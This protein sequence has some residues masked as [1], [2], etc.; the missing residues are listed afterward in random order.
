MPNCPECGK[1][2][3]TGYKICPSCGVGSTVLKVEIAAHIN[4]LR[5]KIQ[6]DP[7][8]ARLCVELG[9][10]Y[11]N[12]GLIHEA[13]DAYLQGVTVDS[14]NFDAQI[15]S[16]HIHLKLREIEKAE[17][18]F[19]AALHI[20]PKSTEALI[21]LFRSYYLQGKTDVAI[22]LGEK[23][24]HSKPDNVEFHKLL[25]ELYTK[26]GDTEKTLKELLGLASLIPTDKQIIREIAVY[27]MDHSNVEKAVEYYGKMLSMS[28][29]D[30]DLGFK[31]GKYYFEKNEHNKVIEYMGSLVLKTD[32]APGVDAS[33]R[34][35]LAL[36]YYQMGSVP[37]ALNLAD[38][39]KMVG[40]H[41]M[42]PEE[43]KMLAGFF[44]K[45]G[46][47]DFHNTQVS[48]AIS[49]FEKAVNYDPDTASYKQ[50]LEKAKKEVSTSRQKTVGIASIIAA[51]VVGLVVLVIVGRTLTRGRITFQIDPP[52]AVTISID[53]KPLENPVVHR[54][55]RLSP[56]LPMGGHRIAIEKEGYEK[57]QGL[58][59]I[60]FAKNAKVSVKLVPIYY[61][62]RVTSVP[63]SSNVTIDGIVVG[64]T[65]FANDQILACPHTIS[66]ERESYAKWL[67]MLTVGKKSVVD[68]GRV[69]LKNLSGAWV[70]K[71]GE[72]AYGYTAAFTMTIKQKGASLTI[73][74]YHQPAEGHVYTGE[75]R[76]RITKNEL[77]A[78]GDLLYKYLNVFYWE[79]TKKKTTIGGK[80]SGDWD[81]IEGTI[82]MDGFDDRNWSANRK[83]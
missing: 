72:D 39:I 54:G 68:L 25:K 64:K 56:I 50:V 45:V 13:L 1:P 63:E 49:S 6:M 59:S 21:G 42:N 35:Y 37:D 83:K 24:L 11:H 57:W 55:N 47:A 29:D 12:H 81:K 28:A 8:N 27:Y 51:G 74:Y 65:P 18:G 66:I 16:A 14:T 44:F 80:L 62:L 69:V 7:S 53:G 33:L 67:R 22:T 31:I 38:G 75:I 82:K 48:K 76:G 10:L 32:L 26:K 46:Q 70:G 15:R 58:A 78:E 3:P 2:I 40:A 19:S 23:I 71:I 43:K 17:K 60:G 4:L 34:A 52:E 9:D 36:A 20:D 5:K 30:V 61:S 41:E 79:N 73:K 77:L